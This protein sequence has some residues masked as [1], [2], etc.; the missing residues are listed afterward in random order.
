MFCSQKRQPKPKP[1]WNN[2]FTRTEYPDGGLSSYCVDCNVW[3]NIAIPT[4]ISRKF[5]FFPLDP[6]EDILFGRQTK[7]PRPKSHRIKYDPTLIVIVFSA[8]TFLCNFLFFFSVDNFT[9]FMGSGLSGG[10]KTCWRCNL[11][12][13]TDPSIHCPHIHF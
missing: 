10:K 2:D 3:I 8:V 1:D 12:Y 5:V 4:E 9:P 7:T 11:E 6:P 13:G